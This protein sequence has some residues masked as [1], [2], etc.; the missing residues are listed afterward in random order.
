MSNNWKKVYASVATKQH[1]VPEGW[2]PQGQVAEEL[3]ISPDKV[4]DFLSYGLK[5]GDIIAQQFPI[6]DPRVGKVVRKTFY[7]DNRDGSAAI[8][9]DDE[10]WEAEQ[11]ANCPYIP[12]EIPDG[13]PDVLKV[14]G[15]RVG[16]K[17]WSRWREIH[18][19]FRRDGSIAWDNGKVSQASV[20]MFKKG[21]AKFVS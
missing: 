8:E 7:K 16:Q 17:V 14:Y 18:G 20:S 5:N 3:G 13:L 11:R 1:T 2:D 12:Q 19:I 21:D 9:L 15:H 10:S 6:F 4:S